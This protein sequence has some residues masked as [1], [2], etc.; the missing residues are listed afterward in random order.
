MKRLIFPLLCLSISSTWACMGTAPVIKIQHNVKVESMAQ[1]GVRIEGLQ[2]TPEV[3][4]IK[5]ISLGEDIKLNV[6]SKVTEVK[7]VQPVYKRMLG[8]APEYRDIN[9][10]KVIELRP[11]KVGESLLEYEVI[12]GEK[13]RTY[14]MTLIFTPG[15]MRGGCGGEP[16]ITPY[17]N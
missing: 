15:M 7:D 3:K 4:S 6:I 12:L 14:K 10:P 9:I 5:R 1:T 13:M 11:E 17:E 16:K 2:E 8:V